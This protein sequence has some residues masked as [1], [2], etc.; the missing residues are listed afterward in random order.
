M[1]GGEE[2]GVER[3]R[4]NGREGRKGRGLEMGSAV[5][6]Y[7]PLSRPWRRLC[8]GLF[9]PYSQEWICWK[10]PLISLICIISSGFVYRQRRTLMNFWYEKFEDRLTLIKV[11]YMKTQD[12]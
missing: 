12:N 2:M 11:S 3:W 6:P 8:S 1:T 9:A 5:E 10:K 7:I 4:G